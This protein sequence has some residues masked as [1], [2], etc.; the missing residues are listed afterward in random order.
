M[1]FLLFLHRVRSSL[2]SNNFSP[3]VWL[4]SFI[5]GGSSPLS[6][7]LS[8]WDFITLSIPL[9]SCG[10]GEEGLVQTLCLFSQKQRGHSFM[11]F[12]DEGKSLKAVICLLK[13]LFSSYRI[14]NKLNRIMFHLIN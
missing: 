12:R 10:N 3:F 7:N 13:F 14:R 2:L 6:L 11:R 9:G 1:P 5:S 8:K 4:W